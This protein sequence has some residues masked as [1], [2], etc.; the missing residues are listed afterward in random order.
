MTAIHQ[1]AVQVA[2][3]IAVYL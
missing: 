1:F 3:H 2:V